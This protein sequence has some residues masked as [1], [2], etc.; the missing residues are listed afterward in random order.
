MPDL[1][2]DSFMN[3]LKK[4]NDKIE[5][6]EEKRSKYPYFIGPDTRAWG[7]KPIVNW[8]REPWK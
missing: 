3:Q 8:W 1:H 2:D 6:I 4:M 7:K 5:K